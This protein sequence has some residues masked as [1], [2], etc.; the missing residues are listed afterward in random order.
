MPPRVDADGFG[1][2]AAGSVPDEMLAAFVVS[3]VAEAAKATPLVFVTVIAPPAAIVA[4]PETVT[5]W[6]VLP[7]PAGY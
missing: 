1:N 6:I 4:S 5:P 3:V 7:V 2:R